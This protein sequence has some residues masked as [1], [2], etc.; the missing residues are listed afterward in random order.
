MGAT[1]DTVM[2]GGAGSWATFAKFIGADAAVSTVVG[3]LEKD[4]PEG[5]TVEACSS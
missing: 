2:L 3:Y 1:A 5:P 4:K